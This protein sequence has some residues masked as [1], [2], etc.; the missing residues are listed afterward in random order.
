VVLIRML[1]HQKKRLEVLLGL[2]LLKSTCCLGVLPLLVLCASFVLYGCDSTLKDNS[3]SK[4]PLSSGA[5][6]CVGRPM[7]S[8]CGRGGGNS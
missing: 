6:H 7:L 3:S 8:L 2:A 1:T 4:G 5:S